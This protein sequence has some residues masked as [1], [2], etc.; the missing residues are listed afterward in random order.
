[1]GHFGDE[2]RQSVA[3]V[4]TNWKKKTKNI[5]P[6]YKTNKQTMCRKNHDNYTNNPKL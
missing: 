5:K 1:M 6:N 2:S 3:L 4:L